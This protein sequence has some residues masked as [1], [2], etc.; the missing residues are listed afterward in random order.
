M[1]KE[2]I[3][4]IF[5]I[6]VAA[7]AGKVDEAVNAFRGVLNTSDISVI[8]EHSVR[9]VDTARAPW[10]NEAW[11]NAAGLDH[12]DM[13]PLIPLSSPVEPIYVHTKLPTAVEPQTQ[14]ID[15]VITE[16]E[17]PAP[18]PAATDKF[19]LGDDENDVEVEVSDDEAGDGD[20]DD[21]ADASGEDA[22]DDEA[23]A[24]GED[25]DDDEGDA[26]DDEPEA[27]AE[28]EAEAEGEAEA[29]AEADE[30]EELDPVRI[31]KVL[32]WK[33][34]DSGDLYAYLPDDEIGDKV[35]AYV[36]GKA[37]FLPV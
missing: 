1:S 9:D 5:R 32:Y 30:V 24:S 17:Q 34:R 36:D 15:L 31:K 19:E 25:A 21:E 27:E 33:G 13:P 20:D 6:A 14:H 37:V 4:Q 23:D 8:D 18:V 28:A 7:A 3:V 2:H 22:D 16:T 10:N 35:G 11:W 26:D 29:E 12:D